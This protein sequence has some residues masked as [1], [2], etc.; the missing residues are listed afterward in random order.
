MQGD[1]N[2]KKICLII[3]FGGIFIPIITFLI[4]GEVYD[5]EAGLYYNV[6]KSKLVFK[7][8][9]K[10]NKTSLKDKNLSFRDEYQEY[11]KIIQKE[12]SI[13]FKYIVAFGLIIVLIGVT[14][15]FTEEFKIF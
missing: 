7:K 2:Y 9:I 8:R 4:W 13:H 12:I 14:V 1:I 6:Q 3:V 15:V 5:P 10:E 11:K